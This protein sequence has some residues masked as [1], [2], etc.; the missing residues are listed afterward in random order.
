LQS[1]IQ[2]EDF[3]TGSTDWTDYNGDGLLDITISGNNYNNSYHFTN[4][5]LNNGANDLLKKDI[6]SSSDVSG[7]MDWGDYDNDGDMDLLL[8]G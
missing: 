6:V 5:Y 3:T 2:L 1:H 4:L 8:S 7:N